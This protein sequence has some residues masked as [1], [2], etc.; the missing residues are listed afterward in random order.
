MK[1]CL[2]CEVLL[3]HVHGNTKYCM[4]CLKERHTKMCKSCLQPFQ[5]KDARNIFCSKSCAMKWKMNR[6][7]FVKQILDSKDLPAIAKRISE[8]HLKNLENRQRLANVVRNL[9]KEEKRLRLKKSWIKRRNNGEKAFK[10][11][12]RG[13]PTPTEMILLG[14]F[15]D[16]LYEPVILSCHHGDG[17]Q[18]Y[19]LPDLGWLDLKLAVEIDGETHTRATQMARDKRKEQ[20]LKEQGWTLLRFSNEQV[21]HDTTKVKEVI[22]STISRLKGIHPTV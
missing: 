10:N 14:L 11:S 8:A 5:P 13:V 12:R 3:G 1:R 17:F 21:T 15:P 7:W 16:A 4:A 19:C 20:V 6:P 22:L 9:S 18:H 2:S